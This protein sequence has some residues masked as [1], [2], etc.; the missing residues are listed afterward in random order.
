M[1]TTPSRKHIAFRII[2]VKCYRN[3]STGTKDIM[4]NNVSTD[5]RQQTRNII[6]P[7]IFV[8]SRNLM[9]YIDSVPAC[10]R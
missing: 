2:V 9:V 5:G 8:K 10:P 6:R 1:R 4:E 7:Q 3:L